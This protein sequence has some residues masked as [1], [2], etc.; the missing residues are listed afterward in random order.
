MLKLSIITINLNNASGLRKTIESVVSQ[1]F[2]DFEYIVIDGGSN[3]GSV[4]MIKEYSEKITYWVSEPDKGI[5]NAMNKGINKANG[6]YCLFLNS[7]DWLVDDNV[8][9]SIFKNDVSADIL[10][11]NTIAI[12]NDGT[13]LMK[14]PSTG[15]ISAYQLITNTLPHQGSYIKRSLFDIYGKYDECFEIVSDWKFFLEMILFKNVSVHYI[16][17]VVSIIDPNGISNKKV[18]LDLSERKKILSGLF[19]KKVIEDYE[20]AHSKIISFIENKNKLERDLEL[21]TMN[22]IIRRHW[23]SRKI[24]TGLFYIIKKYENI[25][26][27]TK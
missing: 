2:S 5:Y 26:E 24:Q 22:K 13:K 12:N 19:P 25:I 15:N 20:Y 10:F 11:G 3:D 17:S 8:I 1:T 7:G 27:R 23:L 9:D 16:N 14:G 6:E 21:V 18:D 4:D